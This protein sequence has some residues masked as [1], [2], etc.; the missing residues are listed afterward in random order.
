MGTCRSPCNC[1]GSHHAV[2]RQ[3]SHVR[4][5]CLVARPYSVVLRRS[6]ERRPGAWNADDF[7]M[8]DDGREVGRIYRL[9]TGTE[10]W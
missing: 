10:S 5:M 7:D 1:S 3:H 4:L 2:G 8:L 9:N 6:Q